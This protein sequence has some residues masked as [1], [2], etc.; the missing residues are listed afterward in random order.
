MVTSLNGYSQNEGSGAS[1][2]PAGP[3]NGHVKASARPTSVL[4]SLRVIHGFPEYE[5]EMEKARRADALVAP[6]KRPAKQRVIKKPTPALAKKPT[7]T[8][9]THVKTHTH[10]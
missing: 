10:A 6:K 7:T 8:T 9:T 3:G 4:E 2:A 1:G 5:E